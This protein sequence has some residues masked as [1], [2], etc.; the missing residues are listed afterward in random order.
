MVAEQDVE[1]GVSQLTDEE[2]K[3]YLDNQAVAMPGT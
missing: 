1:T 2:L 3:W